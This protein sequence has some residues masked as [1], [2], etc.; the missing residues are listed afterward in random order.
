MT[1]YELSVV[2]PVYNEEK[3]ILQLLE[4]WEA[5]FNYNNIQHRYIIINDGSTDKS[6]E[7]L[8]SI[9]KSIPNIEILNHKNEG[10]GPSILKGYKMALSNPWVFQI[11]SDH[12]LE[13]SAFNVLWKERDNYDLLL[14]QRKNKNA[15]AARNFVSFISR[16]TVNIFYGNKISDVNSPY[17]L[18]LLIRK[19]SLLMY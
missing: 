14:A 18:I 12:Q 10:H 9:S 7:L 3:N 2:I 8:N 17:R 5:V 11:D 16:I 13:T 1:K 6:L 4:D 19:P 15:T